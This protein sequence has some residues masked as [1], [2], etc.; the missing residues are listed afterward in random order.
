MNIVKN[1]P[2][3]RFLELSNKAEIASEKLKQLDNNMSKCFLMDKQ[4]C[5]CC[6]T[7][8]R[9]HYHAV[10]KFQEDEFDSLIAKFDREIVLQDKFRQEVEEY[11]NYQMDVDIKVYMNMVETVN[12]YIDKKLYHKTLV[13]KE[14]KE[15]YAQFMVE[16]IK[17]KR[18]I[19]KG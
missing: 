12:Q 17:T 6:E 9:P 7:S 11:L 16:G 8:I 15:K 4:S 18:N 1:I 2:I 14:E 5:G 10:R 3:K 13:T 19:N